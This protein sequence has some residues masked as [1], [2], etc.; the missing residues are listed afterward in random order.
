[1]EDIYKELYKAIKEH[2]DLSDEDLENVANH[3]ADTGWAGFS[4]NDDLIDF[5][6][7]NEENIEKLAEQL[8]EDMGYEN[9]FELANT[10]GRK[11]M[12]GMGVNGYKSLMSWFVLEE[13][14]RWRM[15]KKEEEE[16]AENEEEPVCSGSTAD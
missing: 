2:S 6:D 15:D 13:V 14:A 3:G 10:F 4:Y 16:E 9:S 11:D 8:A 1:M 7:K 5:F 12:L